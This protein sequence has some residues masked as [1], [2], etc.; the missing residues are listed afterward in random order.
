MSPVRPS[1]MSRKSPPGASEPTLSGSAKT[2]F[3]EVSGASKLRARELPVPEV[4]LIASGAAKCEVAAQRKLSAEASGG[5]D[6]RYLS[7]PGLETILN[8]GRGASLSVLR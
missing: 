8:I 2:L 5:S 6:V 1:R 4:R 7:S 3:A